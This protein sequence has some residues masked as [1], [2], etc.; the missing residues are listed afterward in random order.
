MAVAWRA[1][2][3]SDDEGARDADAQRTVSAQRRGP[4]RVGKTRGGS[5][6]GKTLYDA[7]RQCYISRAN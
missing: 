1:R 6:R 2:G 4:A 5:D 7:H 3:D